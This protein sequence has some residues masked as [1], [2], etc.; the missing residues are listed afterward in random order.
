MQKP[1]SHFLNQVIQANIISEV[2]LIILTLCDVM[3]K[4][5]T[6]VVS[7]L[8][9]LKPQ[10]SLE[11]GA[12]LVAQRQ[13]IHLP[14]R[15]LRFYPWVGKIPQRRR[16]QPTRVFLPGKS[17]GWRRLPGYSLRGCKESQLRLNNNIM[18]KTSN[19]QKLG[20]IP[21]NSLKLSE[22]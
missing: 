4:A 8:W 6:S 22:F 14:S 16:W 3:R 1:G 7:S 13:R 9:N 19:K 21:Q 15:R 20:S 11:K 5:F 10:S 18:R 17:H 12:S 2:M